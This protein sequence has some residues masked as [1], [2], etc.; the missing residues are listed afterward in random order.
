MAVTTSKIRSGYEDPNNPG[1]TGPV[2]DISEIAGAYIKSITPEGLATVQL[3]N[4]SETT[5]QLTETGLTQ[6]QQIGLLQ[7]APE[8]AVIGYRTEADLTTAVK[9]INLKILNPELLTGDIWVEGWTQGQRGFNRTKWNNTINPI[10]TVT[11]SWA[12]SVANNIATDGDGELEV[13]LRFFDAATAGNEIERIGVNI[14]IVDLRA[15]KVRFESVVGA[16]PATLPEGTYELSLNTSTDNTRR[17][18]SR[19]LLSDIGTAD[20]TFYHR[21]DTNTRVA[22]TMR[23]AQDTRIL[24]YSVDRR[25]AIIKAIGEA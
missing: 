4:G 18:V 3:A 12:E 25:S 23:Y 14:P 13:R 15:V 20:T 6:A 21:G 19:I 8:P 7:W 24:T 9:T 2:A 5:V 1:Q 17:V 16:S 11:D 10:I 22:I